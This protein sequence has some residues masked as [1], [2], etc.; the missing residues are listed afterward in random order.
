MTG[1]TLFYESYSCRY[2]RASL[3]DVHDIMTN[4]ILKDTVEVND[5]YEAVGL[6]KILCHGGVK[7]ADTNPLDVNFDDY[8][9]SPTGEVAIYLDYANQPE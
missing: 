7:W 2:F 1:N 4:L 6:E 8:V 9:I 5:L 3:K